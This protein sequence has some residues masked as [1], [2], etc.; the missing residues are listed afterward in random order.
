MEVEHEQSGHAFA[1]H[2]PASSFAVTLTQGKFLKEP[3]R[4]FQLANFS[5]KADYKLVSAAQPTAEESHRDGHTC[6]A[7]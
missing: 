3:K 2:Q 5:L 1:K 7:P 6:P 4:G